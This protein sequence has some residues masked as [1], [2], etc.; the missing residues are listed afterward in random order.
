[1]D[2]ELMQQKLKQG[3]RTAF[4]N[5]SIP[6][7]SEYRPQFVFN[8]FRKGRKVLAS[9]ERELMHC[10]SFA[11]SVAFITKS[12]LTPLLP[13]FKELEKR[14]I[15][16]KI[17]TTDYLCF[18][19]PAALDQL[20]TFTNI[21]LR[22]YHSDSQIGFH[23]KGYIFRRDDLY[24]IIVGSSNLTA[25]AL[26][27]N[28]EWNTQL[29]SKAEGEYTYSLIT[30]FNQLW[31]NDRCV[32]YHQA[33]YEYHLA[34]QQN[35]HRLAVEHTL[36]PSLPAN[37]DIPKEDTLEEY[38]AENANISYRTHRSTAILTP[39]AMQNEFVDNMREL[40]AN[41]AKRALLI[42]ATGTG[43]TY[44]SA[45]AVKDFAPQRLLFIVHREQIAKQALKSYRKVIGSKVSMGLLSGT[46]KDTHADY[47]FSTMQTISKENIYRQFSPDEFDYI[48]IDEVHRAGA[49]SY[50][51]I[52]NYFKPKLY[53]GM[54]AT[55]DRSDGYDIYKLF[56]YNIAYEIRLQQAL[57]EDML[58][59]FHYFGITDLQLVDHPEV[60]DDNLANFTRLTSDERVEH[61][62]KE[63][64]FY[65]FS[66]KRVKGL[67][68]CSRNEEAE[69]LSRKFNQQGI[70]TLNLSGSNSQLQREEA[71]ERLVADDR[72]DYLDYIFTVDIFNEGV[73]VPEINQVI[74]LRPTQSPIVFIQQLGRGLRQ[75]AD[76]EYVVILDFIGNYLGNNFMIPMALAGDRSYNK[77]NIRR[78]LLEGSRII[79]GA[80]TIHFDEIAKKRIFQSIDATNISDLRRIKESYQNLKH[81][82]G[83][84]PKLMDF[85]RYGEM[86]VVCIFQN[87]RLGSYHAF[88]KK[89]DKQDYHT[90]FTPNEEMFLKFISSKWAEG[91][92]PHELE[93]LSILLHKP[94]NILKQLE[95]HLRNKW[96]ITFKS[97]TVNNLINIMTANFITGTGAKSVSNCIFLQQHNDDYV[98][99]DIFSQCLSNKSFKQAVAELVNFGLHRYKQN[100]S[101]PYKDSGFQLYQKYEYE[102]VCRILNWNQNIVPLN[103]GG[104]KYDDTTKTFPVFI[105]YDKGDDVQ[106]SINYHDRFINN[107][108]LISL[109][110]NKRTLQSE[111][112]TRFY[113]A[114]KLGIA[115]DL[116]VRKNK[117]DNIAKSFYYLGRMT[118]EH[119]EEVKMQ[120]SGDDAVEMF[121]NLDVSVREDIYDYITSENA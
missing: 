102:D 2:N 29:I 110:K 104:Y 73:D 103:I 120:G 101:N 31:D 105:N 44:A 121:W 22:L 7:D 107:S 117:N 64:A 35:K 119:G 39:N 51:R 61:I 32:D 21:E 43:K 12:G 66:G 23:T 116:F 65:G 36:T 4:E 15:H 67:I 100:Y 114:Q 85:D 20:Q 109:S 9:L 89:Y 8:D 99:S 76:K 90:K 25:N 16:G 6:S 27:R 84:I 69:E 75:N 87:Q 63:A 45:F 50:Q 59:P 48:V 10:D 13:T 34:Y 91:K 70:R 19:D 118:M 77:D 72:E 82:L 106:D 112:V 68:F 18:S 38:V 78:C 54:T 26:T 93:L 56:D 92:R 46:Q 58:C 88:L 24:R 95:E 86:D 83:H 49:E 30:R 94:E 60:D 5:K 52:F 108:Q 28:E 53:L 98:I 37:Y 115:V 57:E 3:I 55:P 42:S 113:N 111:D 80:S 97:N 33:R 11:I 96:Q 79:P 17:I 14:N 47:I 74:M 62:I 41:G 1:M 40:Q 81:K 71:I